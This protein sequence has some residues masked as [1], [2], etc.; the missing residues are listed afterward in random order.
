MGERM[1]RIGLM[2]TDFFLSFRRKC[3]KR[4]KDSYGMTR[5]IRAYLLNLPNPF[6]HLYPK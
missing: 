3:P 6:F 4:Q 5:K 2:D 1:G